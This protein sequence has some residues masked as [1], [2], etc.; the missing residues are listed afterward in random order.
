MKLG[1]KVAQ[2]RSTG[3][4]I[5]NNIK[6]RKALENMGFVWRARAESP[7][8]GGDSEV[9]IS[10][11]QIYD[12][13]V[14]YRQKVK[15]TAPFTV[16][17]EYVVPDEDPWPAN[18]RGLPLG[19]F[20][21]KVNSPSFLDS[22]PDA[23][24]KLAAIGY[25]ADSKEAANNARFE[26]VF[27]ALQRYKEIYGDLL[28]PQPFVVPDGATDWPEDTWGLRLG[29]RVNAVRSQGTFVKGS[30]DR[31]KMLDDIGFVWTPPLSEG[32]R[33][34]RKTNAEKEQE[35]LEA[36]A[37][38]AGHNSQTDEVSDPQTEMD[39]LFGSSFDFEKEPYD[40][41]NGDYA[42]LTWG[43]EGGPELQE[44]AAAKEEAAQAAAEDY[45]PPKNLAESLAEAAKRAEEVGIIEPGSGG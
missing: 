25:Q 45:K 18:T 6:R 1:A 13:L 21:S 22:N 41:G 17:A 44:A 39:A 3:K 9:G 36:M 20:L 26:K 43:L 32:R 8:N 12:A 38:S 11:E 4:Y 16:P 40:A 34:G 28:V 42:S 2:I 7:T 33:R 37:A 27:Y 29:A 15:P 24:E 30:P 19:R 10:F 23:P 5:N 35:E 14:F 31:R